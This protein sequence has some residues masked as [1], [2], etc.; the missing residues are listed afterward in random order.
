MKYWVPCSRVGHL[1]GGG[2]GRPNRGGI[3]SGLDL[4]RL[5][6]GD[7]L[8]AHHRLQGAV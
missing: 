1:Q 7:L 2:A 4:L 3:G 8:V 6:F 5:G